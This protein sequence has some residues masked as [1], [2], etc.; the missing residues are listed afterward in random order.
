MPDVVLCLR[1]FLVCDIFCTCKI[2]SFEKECTCFIFRL[3]LLECDVF[4][5]FFTLRPFCSCDIFVLRHRYIE[6]NQLMFVLHD[7]MVHGFALSK[8]MPLCV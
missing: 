3:L 2:L 5:L 1:N 7:K 4:A 8:M 6:V